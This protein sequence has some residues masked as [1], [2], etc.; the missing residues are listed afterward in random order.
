[1]AMLTK[2]M[3]AGYSTQWRG[4]ERRIV[5]GC[6]L[7]VLAGAGCGRPTSG[8]DELMTEGLSEYENQRYA[9]AIAMFK[10]AAEADRERPEP[11]YYTGLAFLKMADKQFREDDLPGALRYCDRALSTF[12]AAV[13][14]FPGYSRAQQAKADALVLK[15]KHKDALEVATWAASYVGPQAKMHIFKARQF[16]QAG[17]IDK[18]EL[19]FKQAV[20]VEPENPAAYAELGLFYMRC[21]NDAE[22]V[23]ALQ[24]AHAMRPGSPGVVAALARLGA[25]PAYT[26]PQPP[27]RP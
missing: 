11:S 24:K 6:A 18:A 19:Y 15:G 5:I 1:M 12:D 3:R 17:E 7:A 27:A 21:G 26:T 10:N 14:A 13:G 23:K 4:I 9:E 20:S 22:A 25:S 16:A 8:Y 2:V